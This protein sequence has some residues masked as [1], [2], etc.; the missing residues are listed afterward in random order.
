M[1]IRKAELSKFRKLLHAKQA[2]LAGTLTKREEIT[3]QKT[4]DAF[5]E[6]RLANEREMA[7][8]KI[9]LESTLLRKVRS[10]QDRLEQGCYGTCMKC[11][12]DISL[13]RLAAVPWAAYCIR[14]QEIADRDELE[15]AEKLLQV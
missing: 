8:T 4:A 10:A 14:C 11:D 9:N 2:Q 3:I 13:K 6:S 1:A 7:I 15:A 5:D 12:G